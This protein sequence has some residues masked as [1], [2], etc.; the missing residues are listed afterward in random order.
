MSKIELLS[1]LLLLFLFNCNPVFSQASIDL[2]HNSRRTGDAVEMYK[3]ETDDIWDLSISDKCGA[4]VYEKNE[5]F[6]Q[7]T[8]TVL[9]NGTR[10]YY[11]YRCDSLLYVAL[12]NPQNMESFYLPEASCIFPMTLGDKYS[13]ILASHINYCDKL[14]LHKFGIYSVHAD[15]IGTITLRDG[16]TVDNA[17][18]ISSRRKYMYEQLDSCDLDSLPQYTKAEISGKLSTGTGIYTEIERNIYIKGYRYPIIKNLELYNPEGESCLTETYY[19]P[20][21]GQEFL[22]LDEPNLE[23][24][25]EHS[26]ND[27]IS[28]LDE[29]VDVFSFV[30]KRPDA[31]EVVF[32]VERFLAEYP[33]SG[34]ILCRLLLSDSRGIVYRTRSSSVDTS[35][36]KEVGL[37][38]SGLRHGQYVLSVVINNQIYTDNFIVD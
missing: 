30:N 4:I 17:L 24:R 22:F 28:S 29:S 15:S 36:D 23:A 6:K 26:S 5:D 27:D 9:F 8:I 13:G 11:E 2:S 7:D 33:Q 32:D 1:S 14:I 21:E 37:S 31:M 34:T 16:N 38:Y 20:L 35:T 3:I 19:S 12:E 18:Q 25:R 10:K